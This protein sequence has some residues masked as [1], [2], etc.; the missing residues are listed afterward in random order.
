[1]GSRKQKI[2]PEVTT[3]VEW[4]NKKIKDIRKIVL[5]FIREHYVGKVFRNEDTGLKILISVKSARKTAYGEAIYFKKAAA[6]IALPLILKYATYNNF[7][8]RKENDG[9]NILGYLNFKCKIKIDGRVENLRIAVQF[10]TGGKFYYNIE[11]N[12]KK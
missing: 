1:M 7:G 4:K 8:K 3:P 2:V 9:D 5:D 11:V 10:Q 12:K 6:I